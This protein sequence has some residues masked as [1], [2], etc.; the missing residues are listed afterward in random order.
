MGRYGG[1]GVLQMGELPD[2]EVR[3][4]TNV[5]VQVHAVA[6]NPVRGSGGLRWSDGRSW[7]VDPNEQ[8]DFKRRQGVLKML[9]SENWSVP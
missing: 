6:L 9:L 1:P 3:E 2:A 7:N 4:P 5:V 8:L